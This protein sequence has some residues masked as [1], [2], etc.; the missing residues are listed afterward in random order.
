MKYAINHLSIVSVHTEPNDE[1]QICT[2]VLF[3]EFFKVL[4]RR[5]AWSRIR[6][7]DDKSE[8][9][10]LNNQYTEISAEQYDALRKD[11]PVYCAQSVGV[12]RCEN[13]Q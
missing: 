11:T 2:E 1:S 13:K 7:F 3:G 6:L 12:C 9:W 10:V 8:G 5:A 4:E